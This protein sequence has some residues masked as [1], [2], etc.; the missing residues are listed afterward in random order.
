MWSTHLEEAKDE[1]KSEGKKNLRLLLTP[2][3]RPSPRRPHAP[4][5]PGT[6]PP[7][8][9]PHP[10]HYTTPPRQPPPKPPPPARP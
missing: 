7:H 8:Q 4:P 6:T 3:F 2:A 10:H 9:R 1:P 5:W